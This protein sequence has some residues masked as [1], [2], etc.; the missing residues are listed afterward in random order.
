MKRSM[1][2]YLVG[3]MIFTMCLGFS[4]AL[5][6]GGDPEPPSTGCRDWTPC[7]YFYDCGE[8]CSGTGTPGYVDPNS[9]VCMQGNSTCH[10]TWLPYYCLCP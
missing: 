7:C 9:G 10:C 2:L 8:G 3:V 4:Y 1:M 5:A 6:G